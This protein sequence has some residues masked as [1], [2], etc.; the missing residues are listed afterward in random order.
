MNNLDRAAIDVEF[1]RQCRLLI[2]RQF[3]GLKLVGRRFGACEKPVLVIIGRGDLA[4]GI[5]FGARDKHRLAVEFGIG[6]FL[7]RRSGVVDDVE[8][9]LAVVLP[10]P[11]AA[12]DNLFEFAHRTDDTREH[13]VA[14][15]RRIDAGRQ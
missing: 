13:D 2:G 8:V 12:P 4:P 15:G 6:E 3:G 5:D 7:C 9:Q 14:A 10:Q 11:C 1:A